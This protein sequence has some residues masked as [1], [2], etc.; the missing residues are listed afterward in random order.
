MTTTKKK[1]IERRRVL[2]GGLA[3]GSG[4]GLGGLLASCGGGE[5]DGPAAAPA[6]APG[7]RRRG[8]G[9]VDSGGTGMPMEM[10]FALPIDGTAP[11]QAGG[12]R[13]D[14]EGAEIVDGD[15]RP[16]AASALAP[17]QGSQIE[18]TSVNGSGGIDV[19]ARR[20]RVAEQLLGPVSALD[21][22]GGRFSVLGQSVSLGAMT[23]F[24]ASLPGGAA[25][26]ANGRRV[27]VW[28]ELVPG[29]ARVYATRVAAVAAPQNF[30]VRGL[31][32]ALDRGIGRALVGAL[33]VGFD[34]ADAAVV[35]A[36]LR[37][38]DIVRARLSTASTASGAML[39]S[40]VD[41][42]LR[43]ADGIAATVEGRIGRVES[44]T[45]FVVDGITVDA[46]SATRREGASLPAVGG[47]AEVQG[48]ALQGV[49]V[50]SA[51]SLEAPEPVQIEGTIS[52]ADAA[53]RSFL[54]RGLIVSWNEATR[55]EGGSARLLTPRRKAAVVGRWNDDGSR[56]IAEL[57]HVE[58]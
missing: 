44:P 42:R 19:R 5:R 43:L 32:L 12:L 10:M 15:D 47:R 9:G 55:F 58:A 4:T 29:R 30:V 38:G 45:R 1:T 6:D 17:G 56:V 23:R 8:L 51:L 41:D 13:F 49:L 21:P 31:L 39:L 7:E 20:V 2:L 57:I 3:V 18:G 46:G 26:L 35:A 22:A 50:A 28:G 11:L 48:R 53:T 36:G 24:D 27:Q 37:V 54:L 52:T 16:L 14:I 40:M 33:P 34:P 25:D